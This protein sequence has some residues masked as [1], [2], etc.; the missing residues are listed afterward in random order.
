MPP[1]YGGIIWWNPTAFQ[2]RVGST[3]KNEKEKIKREKEFLH[4]REFSVSFPTVPFHPAGLLCR[5]SEGQE[6]VRSRRR[7]P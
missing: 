5:F 7:V 6:E 1:F 3:N 4:I 2:E